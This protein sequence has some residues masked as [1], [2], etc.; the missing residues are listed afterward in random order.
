MS[1]SEENR[2]VPVPRKGPLH[3]IDA[4]GYSIAG[5]QRLWQET[6]ARL[7]LAGAALGAVVLAFCATGPADWLIFGALCLAVLV[8]E[9][10]NTALEVLTDR[11]SPEWSLDAK[12]AKDLGSLAVGLTL[13]AA[14]GY[15]LLVVARAVFA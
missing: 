10:L 12:H 11:I 1:P 9:A 14:S 15:L 6:A 5:M 7:E 8:V 2:A 4:L 3:V 13:F